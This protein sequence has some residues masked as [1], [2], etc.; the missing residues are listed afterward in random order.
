MPTLSLVVGRSLPIVQRVLYSRRVTGNDVIPL[1]R[2]L[3]TEQVVAEYKHA[4]GH[5]LCVHKQTHAPHL[6]LTTPSVR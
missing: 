2:R 1:N 3:V 6:R 4:A 5:Y